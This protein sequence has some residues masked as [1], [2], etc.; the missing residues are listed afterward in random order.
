MIRI[1][2]PGDG[3]IKRLNARVK[4]M[5]VDRAARFRRN[6]PVSGAHWRSASGLWPD[7]TSDRT[8]S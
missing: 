4:Q 1:T 2:A 6:R 7:F 8:G 3:L 5:T